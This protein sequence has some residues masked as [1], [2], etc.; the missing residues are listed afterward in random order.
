MNKVLSRVCSLL[1]R[2]RIK[3]KY[4]SISIHIRYFVTGLVNIFQWAPILYKDRHWDYT[5]IYI[6]LRHKLDLQQKHLAKYGCHEE[7]DR[8]VK[9]I[10]IAIELLRRIVEDDY[11]TAAFE[12]LREKDLL[13]SIKDLQKATSEDRLQKA[14]KVFAKHRK[15]KNG[16]K[17]FLFTHLEKHIEEWWD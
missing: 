16:D 2:G 12:E 10:K 9:N 4:L 14:K 1:H 7:V 6:I 15:R 17:K 8:D 3:L 11:E 13:I 5:Y